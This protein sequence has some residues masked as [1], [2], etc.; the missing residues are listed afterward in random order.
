MTGC[1]F[2]APSSPENKQASWNDTQLISRISDS[3]EGNSHGTCCMELV[4]K[5]HETKTVGNDFPETC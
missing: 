4:A 5:E 2:G 1:I 3:A